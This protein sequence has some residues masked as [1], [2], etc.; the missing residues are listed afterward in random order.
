[1]GSLALDFL[2]GLP[3]HKDGFDSV[4]TYVLRLSRRAHFRKSK[5]IDAAMNFADA[6]FDDIFKHYG[7]SNS[8]VS[9]SDR[10]FC[11]VFWKR[12]MIGS[13]IRLKMSTIVYPQTDVASGIM[14]RMV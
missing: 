6:F 3:N 7:T 5:S 4:L 11:S 2:V 14:N 8:T 12:M 9:D 1:M 13:R 10:K